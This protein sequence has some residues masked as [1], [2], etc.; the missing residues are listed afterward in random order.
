MTAT[1]T[2]IYAYTK[3]EDRKPPLEKTKMPPL[4]DEPTTWENWHKHVNWPQSIL[5]ISVPLLGLYGAFTTELQQK[6]MIWSIIYYFITGL[7]ITAGYHRLWAHRA[8]RATLPLRWLYCFAGSGA[9]E[10][11]IYWWS[12]GH[13]A[14]H[15]WTDTDKDPYSAHRGFFFSHFGWMLVNRPKNRI[16]HADVADLKAESV[17]AIQHKYYPYFALAFGFLLPTLVAGLGWGDFRGGFYY[18]GLCR[19]TFVHHATFCVN[20]L[21]HY[22]GETSFDD[23]HTPR[24]HWITALVTMGEGYHNFHHEFPQDYRNAIV[25]YQY[26]P[27][28]WLIKLL[29]FAGLAYDLKQF[30]SN[31]VTK[32]QIQMQEKKIA[33][34]KRK[35]TYGTRLEDLPVFTWDEFQNLVVN[36]NKKWILIE[37]ILYDM[38]NFIENHPGGEKYIRNGIGKDMTTQFNG[39]VYNH[40]NGARNLLTSMRVGVLKHGME[41]MSRK[42]D[43]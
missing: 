12:R 37:G 1:D 40:S 42:K 34:I 22:L 5:L 10:G 19:L 36:E 16:G 3:S 33:A 38:E 11:S 15:R 13:R 43:E 21:A 17:V 30:P 23:H 41:V 20:S 25:Y 24:D 26:D 39:A 18:A 27:T 7:G 9:V 31:E 28:K 6:T 14:H 29:S 4:F 35:L 8:Y 32:G 2:F